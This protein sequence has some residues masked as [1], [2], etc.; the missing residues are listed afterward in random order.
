MKNSIFFKFAFCMF[1]L[2]FFMTSCSK[3]NVEEI[4]ET[5][6]VI[7]PVMA[8]T[9]SGTTT[10][11]TAYAAY[12]NVN[13][14]EAVAVSNN[15]ALLDTD[16]WTANLAEDDFILHYRNDGTLIT[17]MGGAAFATEV[18]GQPGLTLSL[19]TEAT[20]T[21]DEAN[22]DFVNGSMSGTFFIDIPG[23]NAQTADYSV[24]FSAEV[25]PSVT[26]VFCY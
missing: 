13:G 3:E 5:V 7:Q 18:N 23:P 10:N 8:L 14:V 26:P 1:A 22:S 25:N 12:C 4:E 15:E 11:Y 9:I 16:V 17:T 21:I 2:T 24:E 20:V 6:E 19:D